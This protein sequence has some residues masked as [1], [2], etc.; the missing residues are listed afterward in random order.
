MPSPQKV[1]HLGI[2]HSYERN[3]CSSHHQLQN[4]AL[5]VPVTALAIPVIALAATQPREF[6]RPC[7]P[8]NC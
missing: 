3:K 2:L 4:H 5:V 7:R 6:L 1:L 8:Q